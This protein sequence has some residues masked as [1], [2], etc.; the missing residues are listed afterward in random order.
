MTE[1]KKTQKERVSEKYGAM[2][3]Y[4]AELLAECHNA[5]RK[6]SVLSKLDPMGQKTSATTLFIR[7]C[8]RMDKSDETKQK[9]EKLMDVSEEHPNQKIA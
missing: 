7:T 6:N 1:V 2:V 4:Y 5:V 8:A 3:S 9:A